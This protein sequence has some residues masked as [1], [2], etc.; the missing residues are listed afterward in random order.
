M[1]GGFENEKVRNDASGLEGRGDASERRRLIIALSQRLSFALDR[2]QDI[3]I[4]E[5]GRLLF[6]LVVARINKKMATINNSKS[7]EFIY[8]PLC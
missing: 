5:G 2:D 7:P 8:P 4:Q 1:L 6:F 3:K